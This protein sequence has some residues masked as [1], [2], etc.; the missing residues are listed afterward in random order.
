MNTFCKFHRV[1]RHSTNKCFTLQNA[2]QDLI[3]TG[4]IEIPTPA[5]PPLLTSPPPIVLQGEPSLPAPPLEPS[6]SLDVPPD[7]PTHH[8]ALARQGPQLRQ[9]RGRRDFTPLSEPLSVIFP[10]VALLLR[11]LE[12]HPPPDPLPRWYDAS[13]YCYYHQAVGHSTDGCRTSQGIVQDLLNDESS[14]VDLVDPDSVPP[15]TDPYGSVGPN[16][17]PFAVPHRELPV[18]SVQL[19]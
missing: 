9:R 14:G 17:A 13:P 10:R 18:S 2:V 5:L 7:E 16:P 4:T 8:V 6:P 19:E 12:I 11:I 15:P 3:D 1:S